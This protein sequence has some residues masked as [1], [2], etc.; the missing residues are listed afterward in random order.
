MGTLT[1]S[2]KIAIQD[3]FVKEFIAKLKQEFKNF[4]PIGVS[5]LFL[6]NDSE[7]MQASH[8]FNMKIMPDYETYKTELLKGLQ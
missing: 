2:Q 3:R 8:I 7:F 1:E 4:D 5:I 6:S